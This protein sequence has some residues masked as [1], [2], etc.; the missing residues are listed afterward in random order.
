MHEYTVEGSVDASTRTITSVTANVRVLPWQECPG[1]I[2]SAARIRGMTLSE[3]RD[4]IR[5]EFVGTSTCTHLNDTL[6][7]IADLDALLDLRAGALGLDDVRRV[8][9]PLGRG[10][11]VVAPR[12]VAALDR[13]AH[14]FGRRR[15]R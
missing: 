6:R 11:A 10:L 4:R 12:A 1:A 13:G 2:G 15:C 14:A 3:M 9:P 8:G 5:G 7:A